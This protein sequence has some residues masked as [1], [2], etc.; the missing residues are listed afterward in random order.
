MFIS[1]KKNVSR[2]AIKTRR[3]ENIDIGNILYV[4][5]RRTICSGTERNHCRPWLFTF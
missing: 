3:E 5:V 2:K 4:L 1:Q